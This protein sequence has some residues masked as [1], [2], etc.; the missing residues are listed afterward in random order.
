MDDRHQA[1]LGDGQGADDV[2]AFQVCLRASWDGQDPGVGKAT[3]PGPVHDRP[4]VRLQSFFV[5]VVDEADEIEERWIDAVEG[6]QAVA[7]ERK[8]D[9]LLSRHLIRLFSR[10]PSVHL[11]LSL[12]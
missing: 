11:D 5:V 2:S 9:Q 4:G 1:G 10:A 6:F 7:V 8:D 3:E 12:D